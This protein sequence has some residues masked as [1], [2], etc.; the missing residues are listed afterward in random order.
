MKT[1]AFIFFVFFL[2]LGG[3]QYF[4]A[5]T[6]TKSNS[7]ASKFYQDK[8]VK[9]ISSNSFSNFIENTDFDNEEEFNVQKENKDD[10]KIKIY[11]NGFYKSTYLLK[12]SIP[13]YCFDSKNKLITSIL[14]YS[15]TPLYILQEVLRI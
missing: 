11:E 3:G 8:N 7:F 10:V 6:S 2:L 5:S 14:Y 12:S 15:T 13:I 9:Q 4:Y 1:R